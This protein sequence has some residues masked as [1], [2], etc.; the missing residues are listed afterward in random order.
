M[1]EFPTFEYTMSEVRRAGKALK[2]DII[3][4][5]DAA[6]EIKRVFRI[7]NDWR[8]SHA[9]PMDRVRSQ[10][11]GQL[12]RQ[13]LR[14]QLTAARLKR[15]PSIRKKLR[16]RCLDVIQDLAGVR[17][18]L[19]TMKNVEAVVDACRTDLRHTVYGEDNYIVDPRP[20]GYRS[21]HLKLAYAPADQ[22]EASFE[23]RRVELQ[24]RSRLQ[25][26]WATAVEA[27]GLF[28]GENLKGGAGHDEWHRLFILMA[29][30]MAHIEGQPEV[31]GTP[32]RV[33]RVRELKDLNTRLDAAA[34]LDSI[35]QAVDFTN[36][37]YNPVRSEFYLIRYDLQNRSVEVRGFSAASG[38]QTLQATEQQGDRFDAVLVASDK[39]ENLKRAFPNYFGDVQH[40]ARSLRRIIKGKDLPE[41]VLAPQATVT[42]RPR[43]LVDP[44]WLRRSTRP[45][46]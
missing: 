3:W 37:F 42:P 16:T 44:R 13:R 14:G 38:S 25:H 32:S 34:F 36:R 19:P 45:R 8:D 24:I 9:H 11:I 15:M 18:I 28:R 5:E 39:I 21:H 22:S 29:S 35:N 20:S 41:Y 40:F 2:G 12:A 4:S 31:A 27:V 43:D 23:G 17:V 26:S 1:N 30:E 46:V 33:D 10:V 7:A 6:P